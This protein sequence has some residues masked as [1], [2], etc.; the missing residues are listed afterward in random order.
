MLPVRRV[1]DARIG[2]VHRQ[3][4]GARA[5]A[6]EVHPLPGR[7]TV[8]R[9]VDAAFLRRPVR[10]PLRRH[11][12]QVRVPWV[13]ADARDRPRLLQ[14][15]VRPS[16]TAVGGAVHAVAVRG[17][18]PAHGVLSHAHVH[19]VRVRFGDRD[20]PHGRGA[21]EAVRDVAPAQS[22]VL[23]LP[24][25]ATRAAE[26]V[27][28][29]LADH[30]GDRHRTAAPRRADVA[31]PHRCEVGIRIERFLPGRWLRTGRPQ[32][33]R[34]AEQQDEHERG[35]DSPGHRPSSGQ[36]QRI[37]ARPNLIIRCPGS[38]GRRVGWLS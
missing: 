27:G 8:T 33:P 4:A 11:V 19:H 20:R 32:H 18:N 37:A 28:E 35:R 10:R 9:A 31:P 6:D 23:G 24:D 14:P 36:Q 21:E 34:Q 38:P 25:T 17:R 5:L 1:Q 30:A 12:H 7:A 15:D 22:A 16:T 26:V 13:H 3:V 2:H 29:R